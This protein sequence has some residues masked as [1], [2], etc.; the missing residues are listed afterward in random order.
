MDEMNQGSREINTSA[1]GVS[2]LATE[3]IQSIRTLEELMA[4]F[5]I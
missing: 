2:D 4:K 3:T 1:H 5:N